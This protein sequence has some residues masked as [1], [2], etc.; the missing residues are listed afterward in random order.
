MERN[1]WSGAVHR[2]DA[3]RLVAYNN[4]QAA[5][6]GIMS[7]VN[8]PNGAAGGIQTMAVLY[9]AQSGVIVFG[10]MPQRGIQNTGEGFILNTNTGFADGEYHQIVVT[11]ACQ[12]LASLYVDGVLQNQDNAAEQNATCSSG[13]NNI[14]AQIL[15]GNVP[16]QNSTPVAT[17][18]TVKLTIA[19]W[20]RILLI[21]QEISST[22]QFTP[23][24]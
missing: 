3:G 10:W 1:E 12:G 9:L 22:S 17:H 15:L 6:A 11:F 21:I 24:L 20:G 2:R 14:N 4:A 8:N 18:A 19:T 16:Y 5:Y 13:L 7:F 23:R